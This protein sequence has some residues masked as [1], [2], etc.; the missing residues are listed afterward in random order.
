MYKPTVKG[1]FSGCGGMELGL[2]LAGV[3]LIQSLDLDKEA[4]EPAFTATV[5]VGANYF[6]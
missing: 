6:E 1:Y 2:L 3:K 4:T 5:L